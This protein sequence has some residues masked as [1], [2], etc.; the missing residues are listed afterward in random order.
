MAR[1]ILLYDWHSNS[2]ADLEES[3]RALDRVQVFSFSGTPGDYEEDGV[4]EQRLAGK[5]GEWGIEIC[6]SFDYFPVI[7]RVCQVKDILYVSWIY[8]CPHITLYSRTAG[9]SCNLIFSFDRRQVEELH[10]RGIHQV[11]HMPLAVNIHYLD[12]F[13]LTVAGQAPEEVLQRQYGAQLSFVGSIYEQNY[14]EGIPYLPPELKGYLEGV[15]QAQKQMQGMELVR[16]LL[17]EEKMDAV[18]D[19]VKL[20]EDARY[21]VSYGQ[22]FCD[23]FLAKYISSLE[24]KEILQALGKCYPVKLYSESSWRC[25]GLEACGTVDYRRQMPI[26]FSRTECNLNMTIRS[27]TSGIPLRC[28]DIMG[29]GGTLF[30]N[31]QLELLEYFEEGEEFVSFGSAEEL[32]DKVS[33]YRERKELCRKIAGKGQA[34]VRAEFHY[35][36]L[37]NR[38]LDIAE[39]YLS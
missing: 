28:L 21:E 31:P 16:R 15:C 8:D 3:L 18:R 7:S 2:Q 12:A 9:N 4:F 13:L 17:T 22:L 39:T 32:L 27:I 1:R 35:G 5:I 14:Y 11:V 38:I 19:Y 29:A 20:E 6:F 23:L 34:R 33:F 36:R 37:L 10:R 25:P 30:S 24:R 26:V